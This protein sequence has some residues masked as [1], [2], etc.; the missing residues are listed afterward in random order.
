MA[1]RGVNSRA[2]IAAI[3]GAALTEAARADDA[4]PAKQRRLLGEVTEG[5]VQHPCVL[6]NLATVLAVHH[7]ESW[8]SSG[9]QAR[10]GSA[11]SRPSRSR[12]SE[13]RSVKRS[14]SSR[15]ASG[16][17]PCR[18]SCKA[19]QRCFR[20]ETRCWSR[21]TGF[22]LRIDA[23]H[24]AVREFVAKHWTLPF[25]VSNSSD[26][27]SLSRMWSVGEVCIRPRL[28]ENALMV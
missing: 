6:P 14:G 8:E 20:S 5:A 2:L 24:A 23:S 11:V 3:A 18:R 4:A 12:A 19:T 21:A 26:T 28:C 1:H 16:M 13:C 22:G 7:R 25:R 15:F 17:G 9:P 10:A 27:T